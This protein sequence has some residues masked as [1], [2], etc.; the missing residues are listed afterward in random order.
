MTKTVYLNRKDLEQVSKILD[1][2]PEVNSFSI[3]QDNSSGIG[4]ITTLKL[5]TNIE[6]I[7]GEFSVEISGIEDW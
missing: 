6:G 7:R 5:N 3:E 4:D 2:F 1:K